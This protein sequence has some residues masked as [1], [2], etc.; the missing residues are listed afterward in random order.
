MDSHN[1]FSTGKSGAVEQTAV[2][3][4]SQQCLLSALGLGEDIS[5]ILLQ[6]VS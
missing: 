4:R 1:E 2:T 3:K 6:S 5:I